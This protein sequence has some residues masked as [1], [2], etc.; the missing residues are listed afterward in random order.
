[1]ADL[2]RFKATRPV[3]RRGGLVLGSAAWVEAVPT[4]MAKEA[5][6]ALLSDP[7]VTVEIQDGDDWYRMSVEER[8]D[9]AEHVA[10]VPASPPPP[11]PP[12]SPPP[13]PPPASPPPPAPPPEP[14]PKPKAEKPK[15]AKKSG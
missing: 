5:M 12:P 9:A 7:V 15:A 2:V 8:Q 13:P 11:P 6:I 4:E 10:F 14:K 3:Y 1:M